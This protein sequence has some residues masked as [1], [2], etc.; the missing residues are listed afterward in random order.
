M[1][2]IFL[3]LFCLSSR[4]LI[5]QDTLKLSIR[6][7]DSLFIRTNLL[8]LAERYRIEAAQAQ[9]LQASLLDNPSVYLELSSFNTASK[10]RVLDVGRKGEK[11]ITVQ[12]LLYTAGKRNKRV[13]LAQEAARL[14][15]YEFMD[16]MRALRFE[17]RSRFYDTYFQQKTLQRY[18][19]QI[20]TIQN[21]VTAYEQQYDR[22]NVSL[23][24][25]LR[26]KALLFQLRND[27]TEIVFQLAENQRSLRTLLA[28]EWPVVPLV[29][30]TTL[31]RYQLNGLQ[32][33]SLRNEAVRNRTDVKVTE[34]L[35]RQAELNYNLQ[36]A[37]ARPDVRVGGTYDQSGSYIPNYVG[38]GISMDVPIFNRNQGGIKAAKSQISFQKQQEQQKR[39]QVVNEVST[40]LVKVQEVERM[41]QSVEG[42]FTEQFEQLNEG[43]TLSFGKGN[44]SLLEFVDLIETYNE[45]IRELNRLKA[46]RIG[47]YEELN[48]VVGQE[49][50]L[51]N[52]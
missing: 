44:I 14:T 17:L 49:L 32:L 50:F 42:R 38:L 21:T 26:L 52:R 36:R 10:S 16:L 5:A 51:R 6:Q 27:R 18:N 3:L 30:E 39:L 1:R 8:L 35:T 12:Q 46:D 2:F 41:V 34:S 29:D 9:T 47:A 24:E 20:R 22:N 13:A 45:S 23:R 19:Q 31:T 33:D 25:L 15:E 28:T 43:V 7:A 4:L 37:L 40:A 48:Y 11:I